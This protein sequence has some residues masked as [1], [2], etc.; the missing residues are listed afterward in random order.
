[1]KLNFPKT[2]PAMPTTTQLKMT[3]Q[4]LAVCLPVQNKNTEELIVSTISPKIVK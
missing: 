1:M 4:D 2:A 3:V